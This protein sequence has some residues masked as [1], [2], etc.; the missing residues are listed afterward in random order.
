MVAHKGPVTRVVSTPD[1]KLIVSAGQDGS[2]FIYQI[3]EEKITTVSNEV[4]PTMN[5]ARGIP[6]AFVQ[7]QVVTNTVTDME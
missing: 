5:G 6:K 4:S 2:L 1:S 7:P 3:N